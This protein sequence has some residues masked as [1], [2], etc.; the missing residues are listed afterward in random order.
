MSLGSVLFEELVWEQ[1]Q[2]LNAGLIDY[3]LPRA[4]NQPH[5]I[6]K[7]VE[8]PHDR[9][10]FGA[11]GLGDAMPV[12]TPAAVVNAVY[13]ATGVLIPELPLRPERVHAALK[14]RG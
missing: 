2:L 6:T 5:F 3:P 9:G 14:K 7:I 8:R 10:G 13:D 12:V 4:R 11:K 1:G